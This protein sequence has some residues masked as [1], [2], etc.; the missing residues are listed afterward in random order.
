MAKEPIKKLTRAEEELMQVLWRLEKGFLKE[1][2]AELSE[3]K[4][5]QSTVSTVLKIME[6][7]GFVGHETY[8]KA[9]QY[10]PVV[11]KEDYARFYFDSFLGRYFEGSFQRLLSFF[12][13]QGDLGLEELDEIMDRLRQQEKPES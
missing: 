10:F 1:I 2:L 11:S 13:K 4:P 5:K 3:P 8:G 12:H 9:H 7:K 6:E